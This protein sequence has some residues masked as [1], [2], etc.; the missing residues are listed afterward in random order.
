MTSDKPILQL[1][2]H[3]LA[4]HRR[5]NLD[6]EPFAFCAQWGGR[7]RDF[8]G[9]AVWQTDGRMIFF[10]LADEPE[11]GNF[12]SAL[13]T[14]LAAAGYQQLSPAPRSHASQKTVG[15]VLRETADEQWG[16]LYYLDEEL[17]IASEN[18]VFWRLFLAQNG[19]GQWCR[20]PDYYRHEAIFCW[21]KNASQ[22]RQKS[23]LTPL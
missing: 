16:R 21:N 7:E 9:Q 22:A 4:P 14:T 8:I 1:A 3:E 2:P 23:L 11:L 17:N 12:V 19:W 18:P 10:A 15:R 6:S 5:A 20:A 13:F